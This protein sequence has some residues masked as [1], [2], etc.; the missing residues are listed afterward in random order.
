MPFDP[1]SMIGFRKNTFVSAEQ[2]GQ[3]LRLVMCLHKNHLH[4]WMFV[5]EIPVD[6]ELET[7]KKTIKRMRIKFLELRESF[8]VYQDAMLQMTH[9][10]LDLCNKVIVTYWDESHLTL[11]HLNSPGDPKQNLVTQRTK[12]S[13][14][15]SD[16]ITSVN[17]DVQISFG[18]WSSQ[19]AIFSSGD[20]WL[21]KAE[22]LEAK[23]AKVEDLRLQVSLTLS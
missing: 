1:F 23:L 2:S 16:A 3:E 19:N 7:Q 5:V 20:A 4:V 13:Q 15:F 9:H 8:A 17:D 22:E 18:R 21:N 12:S 11:A 10:A 14:V 6:P